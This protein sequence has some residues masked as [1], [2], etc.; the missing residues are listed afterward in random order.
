MLLLAHKNMIELIGQSGD[1]IFIFLKEGL[2]ILKTDSYFAT[3]IASG[4]QHNKQIHKTSIAN[5]PLNV[6]LSSSSYKNHLFLIIKQKKSKYR[7]PKFSIL[8]VI[9]SSK[10]TFES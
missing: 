2:E 9:D 10:N 6:T 1:H 4:N 3:L 8:L 7:L 5:L